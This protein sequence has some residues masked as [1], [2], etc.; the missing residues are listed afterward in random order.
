MIEFKAKIEAG[1]FYFEIIA[2]I[3]TDGDVIVR[4]IYFDGCDEPLTD[5][6][7]D[8]FVKSYGETDLDDEILHQYDAYCKEQE[9]DKMI[10]SWQIRQLERRSA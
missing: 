3:Y 2:N 10:E 8:H 6:Q 4:K 7:S 1:L 9:E 5:H